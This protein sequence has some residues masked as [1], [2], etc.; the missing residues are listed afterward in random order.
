MTKRT[1]PKQLSE[2]F[3]LASTTGVLDLGGRALEEVPIGIRNLEKLTHLDLSFNRLASIP[4]WIGNLPNLISL[5]LRA[6]GLTTLP[7][8][9]GELKNLTSLNLNEN[10]LAT[11][12]SAIFEM[13]RLTELHLGM[14]Q[15]AL[16][17]PEIN[18]L[19]SLTKLSLW[20]N[21]LR[22]LPAEIGALTKLAE[23]NLWRNQMT[24]VPPQIGDLRRL[25]QLDLRTNYISTLPPEIGGLKDL[26]AFEV[27]VNRLS[28]LPGEIGE[29]KNLCKLGLSMNRLTT[30]PTEIGELNLLEELD[31]SENELLTLPADMGK[32][33]NLRRLFLHGNSA[34]R[35]DSAVLGSR[36]QSLD[37]GS[38]LAARPGDILNHYFTKRAEG[39]G[40]P[41]NEV[42]VL[43][44][45]AGKVGKS[46]I[47]EKLIYNTFVEGKDVETPGI[48]IDDMPLT[49]EGAKVTAH[50]WDFAGQEITHET[51]RF[52]LTER[53]LYLVVLEKRRDQE[54]QD[55][56]YWLEHIKR[57]G[58]DSPVIVVLN[59]SEVPWEINEQKLLRDHP[60]IRGFVR[61]ACKAKGGC[62]KLREKIQE[63]VGTM[64]SVRATW[65]P[66]HLRVKAELA[67]RLKAGEPAISY[68]QYVEICMQHGVD[69][70]EKQ[71]GLSRNLHDIGAALWYG[72]DPRLRDTRVLRPNW[73][74]NGLYGIIRGA[75]KNPKERPAGEV[76]EGDVA[77]LLRAAYPDGHARGV[78]ASDYPP[79]CYG[80]LLQ[81]LV[82]RD[83]ALPIGQRNGVEAFLLP[84]L[85]PLSEPDPARYDVAAAV[86]GA[87]VRFRYVF[88]APPNF[89]MAP[90]IVR[91]SSMSE[92]TPRWKHGVV[93]RWR[94][95]Q[96][97]V[98]S[99][100]GRSTISVYSSGDVTERLELCGIVRSYVDSV[101]SAV[102]AEA[103]GIEWLEL[104][105]APGEWQ[106]VNWLEDLAK[107]GSKLPV[108]GK[109]GPV[110]VDAGAELAR[111]RA[112]VEARAKE[113][114]VRIFMSYAHKNDPLW[115][116]IDPH[117]RYF[118]STGET[119]NWRDVLLEADNH[120]HETITGELRQADIVI[121]LVSIDFLSSWYVTKF[122]LPIAIERHKKGECR[123]LPVVLQPTVAV[124]THPFLGTLTPQPRHK[125]SL[126]PISKF[127]RH[128]DGWD[129]IYPVLKRM[130]EDV[131][132]KRKGRK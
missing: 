56:Q 40:K 57:Y 24:T 89:F 85:L 91:T 64:E 3:A 18:E 119:V 107:S 113:T 35:I 22:V 62:D 1:G 122:E 103:R 90:F 70:Q 36:R 51:H 17:P 42:K 87:D 120:Y 43:L 114:P 112:I 15:I 60:N 28:A 10:G 63:V 83:L 33:S 118:E 92:S 34:L 11:M 53:S 82:D 21:R 88:Q 59:K 9:L 65:P 55:A 61:T 6:N 104:E 84:A 86:H 108:R 75:E 125:G 16:L 14:N 52:F 37:A 72:D 58:K 102:A 106:E 76:Y 130:V 4:K 129:Q 69:T 110:E 121:M 54:M 41:L 39:G 77:E 31:L 49:V 7:Q 117:L 128:S 68:V 38:G 19:E 74:A 97:L 116:G 123:V 66:S 45:G 78:K 27:A 73:V 79:G 99:D 71:N 32:L 26:T 127:G 115:R 2:F 50:L 93:L 98:M 5:D 109:D 105:A 8:E 111:L 20:E 81:L 94:T 131:K 47:V 67:E 46:T 95:A 30:L 13:N 124:D 126:K 23:L 48:A 132:A 100:A 25:V 80:F 29:L 44:V 12:P 101:Q 96:A